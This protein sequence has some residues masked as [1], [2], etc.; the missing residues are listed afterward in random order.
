MDPVNEFLP[1]AAS[2]AVFA[3]EP[4]VHKA[5]RG[6][7]AEF[8]RAVG[9]ALAWEYSGNLTWIVEQPDAS[10]LIAGGEYIPRARPADEAGDGEGPAPSDAG[11]SDGVAAAA[12]P[13]R[14]YRRIPA[15][16]QSV[17]VGYLHICAPSRELAS[18][19]NSMLGCTLELVEKERQEVA[20]LEE[21]SA[22]WESL[23]ALF[24][25]TVDMRN[26]PDRQEMLNR[27][28]ER[29][30]AVRSGANAI[31]WIED[32]GMLVPAAWVCPAPPEPRP[33][34]TGVVGRALDQKSSLILRRAGHLSSILDNE[35]E[36]A[37]AAS[38]VVVPI[39]TQS[40]L[41]GALEVWMDDCEEDFESPH[42]RLLE[43]LAMQAALVVE[44]ER[45]Y[46]VQLESERLRQEVDIGSRIQQSLLFSRV[47]D[48]IEG[49]SIAA[50]TLPS[51]TIDGDFYDI[52]DYSPSCF[53]VVVGD[54]MGKGIPAAILAA[55]A[56]SG[57]FRS[58]CQ[59]MVDTGRREIPQADAI[60]TSLNAAV[61]RQMISVDSF[62]SLS[63][64][65]F[66]LGQGMVTFVDAGHTKT[67]HLRVR[68]QQT[69]LLQGDNLPLGILQDEVYQQIAHRFE[70]G[71]IFVFYSDGITE[72]RNPSGEFFGEYR[73]YE[74]VREFASLPVEALIEKIRSTVVAFSQREIFEDDLTCVVIRIHPAS[75]SS[76]EKRESRSFASDLKELS[77]IRQW[78][79][80]LWLRWAPRSHAEDALYQ[81]ILAVNEVASNVMRHAYRGDASQRLRIT[82]WVEDQ[83]F[84]LEL[85]HTGIPFDPASTTP[86]SFD[87]T[88]DGGFGIF[89]IAKSVDKIVYTR[90]DGDWHTIRIVKSFGPGPEEAS[91]G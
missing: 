55:A 46:A 36:L 50:V 74:C 9:A 84:C 58:L 79:N 14:Y 67:F 76:A 25:W 31:L 33:L 71:D 13:R 19:L 72:A 57:L 6:R 12:R 2:S 77:R 63:Y 56:K 35:P 70:P 43:A 24:E 80:D 17:V 48:R 88:R 54:V 47:P 34:R 82:A 10:F 41:H 59:L 27:I 49:A 28:I 18:G 5:L 68:D 51:K 40:Q 21:L 52:V 23:D 4:Q 85:A 8:A 7:P 29:A 89:I 22:S 83:R 86:P 42:L 11:S 64:A 30:V 75:P 3:L 39:S 37:A 1:Y 26:L 90:N 66:D 53:D 91:A 81:L 45:L 65:R 69:F 87:G 61:A 32:E 16:L 20:L 60:V 78:V 73:L 62:A 15:T 38:V 44:N